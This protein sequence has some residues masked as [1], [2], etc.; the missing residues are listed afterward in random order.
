MH[1]LKLGPDD[2]ETLS[3]MAIETFHAWAHLYPDD[4]F[5]SYLDESFSVEATRSNLESP[6]YEAYFFM[7]TVPGAADGGARPIGY[8]QMR[9]HRGQ[10]V[11]GPAPCVEI[12]RFYLLK[13]FQGQGAGRYFLN[14]TIELLLAKGART[15][16][17]KVWDQNEKA[18]AL[19]R[20]KGFR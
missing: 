17:L 19:Y 1:L 5:R 4:V 6:E 18:L 14:A 16:W 20:S 3:A 13:E 2:A 9:W 11:Q 7:D 15:M 12:E 10:T 8:C